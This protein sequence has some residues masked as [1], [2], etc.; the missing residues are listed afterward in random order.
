VVPRQEEGWLRWILGLWELSDS[1]CC[2]IAGVAASAVHAV[3]DDFVAKGQAFGETKVK[4]LEEGRDT[5]EEADALD[6]AGFGL[7]E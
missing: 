7:L 6:G 3:L 5:G 4:V 2:L 1:H